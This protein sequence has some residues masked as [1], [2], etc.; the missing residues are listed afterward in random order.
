MG[1]SS[2]FL[3][4]VVVGALTDLEVFSASDNKKRCGFI[5]IF[6]ATFLFKSLSVNN[7]DDFCG[8]F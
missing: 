5:L 4:F 6:G 7:L 8:Y 2:L 1:E 3:E